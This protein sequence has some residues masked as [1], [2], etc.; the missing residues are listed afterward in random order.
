MKKCAECVWS[1]PQ[2]LRCFL[3]E[4]T[5]LVLGAGSKLGGL[6][7]DKSLSRPAGTQR[8]VVAHLGGPSEK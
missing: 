3:S 6:I 1:F 7:T 4:V 2:C 5:A 8:A